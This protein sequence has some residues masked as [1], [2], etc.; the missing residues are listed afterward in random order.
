MINYK[1]FK[2]NR[3]NNCQSCEQIINKNY[4]NQINNNM[5]EIILTK[6]TQ[7]LGIVNYNELS[8]NKLLNYKIIIETYSGH[9]KAC[10]SC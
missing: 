5:K 3:T 4:G 8:K 2:P 7:N 6:N 9:P 10:S 1:K